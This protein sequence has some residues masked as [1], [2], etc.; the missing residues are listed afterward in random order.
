[1]A[2]KA[3]KKPSMD[4]QKRIVSEFNQLRQKQRDMADKTSE[5]EMELQEHRL[6]IDTLK[7]MEDTRKCFR[8]VGGVLTERTVGDVLPALRKNEGNLVDLIKSLKG[9]IEERGRELTTFREK[10]NIQF[11]GAGSEDNSKSKDDDEESAAKP[12]A[13]VLV[14]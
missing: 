14:A 6:V 4:D 8:I 11:Q 13:G 1:M 2:S 12:S 3:A 5:M 7:D 9:Q 10:H